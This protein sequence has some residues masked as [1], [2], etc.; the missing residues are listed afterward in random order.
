MRIVLNKHTKNSDLC[1]G[2][3]N[4]PVVVASEYS[5]RVN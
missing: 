3:C 5:R 2:V 1:P 4:M